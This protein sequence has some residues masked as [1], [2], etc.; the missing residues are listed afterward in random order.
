MTP[1]ASATESPAD[2]LALRE[3]FQ[4]DKIMLCFNG[5]I[6]ATL[7]EEIGTALRAHMER[8]EESRSAV[9]DVF[10]VYIEM[11]QNIR[12]YVHA[13][14]TLALETASLFVSRDEQGH[15]IVTAGNVV[16]PDDG[17]ALMTR[18]NTL[19]AMDK[20]ELKAA[21]KA[22]LRQ[23]RAELEGSAGL[24]LIDMAR[25]ATRPLAATLSRLDERHCFFCLRVVL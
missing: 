24:G 19:A 17:A 11:T 15:Y 3:I 13:H 7:I 14:D 6:T 5:P 21:F 25:K 22:Q 23:P 18:I 8:M 10:S 12:R 1:D 16:M 2:L 9:S 20:A 4:R